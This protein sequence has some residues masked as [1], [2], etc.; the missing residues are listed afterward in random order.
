M[1]EGFFSTEAGGYASI[2]KQFLEGAL[3]LSE[4]QRDRGKI[5]FRPT[6]ALAG[7]GL[8][9]LLKACMS[10]NREAPKTKGR[11][12]HDIVGMWNLDVC[13]PVRGHVLA[14]AVRVAAESRQ[15]VGYLVVPAEDEVLPLIQ[16][17]VRTLGELHGGGGFPL[18][19]PSAAHT[20]APRT[21]FLVQALWTTADD[22]VKRPGDFE[23]KRF[24]GQTT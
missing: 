17:Y 6:L 2:A 3:V 1:T 4:A 24:R 22:F 13:E 16:E 19:Y 23:L 20:Q 10:L 8:E 14:N 7:Q 11:D 12:G 9:V 15:D 5:L 18:R 21:P